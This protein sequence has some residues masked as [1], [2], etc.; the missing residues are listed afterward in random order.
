MSEKRA[1]A[2]LKAYYKPCVTD[3]QCP[4]CQTVESVIADAPDVVGVLGLILELRNSVEP[5]GHNL[6]FRSALD[7]V[8]ERISGAFHVRLTDDGGYEWTS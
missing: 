5:A 6:P 2:A 1:K 4:A 3:C 8:Y 7:F